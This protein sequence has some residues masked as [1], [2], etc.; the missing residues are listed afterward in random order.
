MRRM[1]DPRFTRLAV[2]G[3]LALIVASALAAALTG[4]LLSTAQL[5][6][7]D[8]LFTEQSAS[9]SDAVVI[10]GID[11]RSYRD[12]LPRYG[13]LVTWPRDLYAQVIDELAEAGVR[14]IGLDLFFD[15]SG[16]NDARLI[17]ALRR[18]GNVVFPVEAQGPNRFH[19]RPG[20]LQAFDLFVRAA[21]HL[22]EA[23]STEGSVNVTTDRDT[24]VR[25]IPLILESGDATVP[26]FA[27]ATV[28]RYLR[29]LEVLDQPSTDRV[30]Y[31]AG[32][33]IPVVDNGRMLIN[34][35][36]PPSLPGGHGTF[37]ILP[38]VD[39]VNGTFDR[40]AVSDK[41]AL[42]GLTVRGID[43]FATPTTT[44]RGMWGVELQASA[45][46]T[47]LS[48]RYLSPASR[49][50]TVVLLYLGALVGSLLA[51][52]ARPLRGIAGLGGLF[53]LYLFA[54]SVAFDRGLL[55][56]MVYP[57]AALLFGFTATQ[58]YRIF[59]EQAQRQLV[60][61]LM[62]RYLSPSVSQWVLKQPDQLKLGGDT[63]VMTVLFCDLRG[64][65]TLSHSLEP[66]ALVAF[67]NEYMTAMTEVVFRYD[68]VLDKYIGDEIMAFWNAPRDQP[69]H[70]RRACQAALGMAQ[71]LFRLRRS[72]AERGLP[73]LDIGI[74]INS[75]PM[76][77]GNMGSRDRLAYT[78]IG[79]TVNVASR[80]QSLNKE[81]GTRILVTEATQKAAG[82]GFAYRALDQVKV[83]GRDEALSLYELRS[84]DDPSRL[85]G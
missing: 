60:Q 16:Q 26:A 59:F 70:A 63:R 34:Y 50:T 39:V 78:V 15:A 43:E 82:E 23:G 79:D 57:I 31:A 22:A 17:A 2:A 67:I 46:D 7:T 24:V 71:E 52:V 20:V 5:Q 12:L 64:F 37:T 18:A 40:A 51:A 4:G 35:S 85:S 74:G 32:R 41:I 13:P 33:A 27:L 11:Q 68:G 19:P 80:L 30:V 48:E 54:S 77:V 1:W 21:P 53:L 9:L 62:S 29:R 58:V 72:W 76:V 69:D 66:Q 3:V 61:E 47:I 65:T 44:D 38:F 36:G 75:G 8:F 45:I 10:V 42:I 83:R 84:P 25:G 73:Q 14:V 56:N 55:L 81:L 28:A 49:A 6:S